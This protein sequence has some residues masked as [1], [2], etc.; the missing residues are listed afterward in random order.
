MKYYFSEKFFSD[1]DF[2]LHVE[3]A[4]QR[5]FMV[6]HGHDFIELVLVSSGKSLH[7]I[8]APAGAKASYGLIRGEVF[9]VMPGEIHS[10]CD[11]KNFEI[12]N[13]AFLPQLIAGEMSEL[14]EL[15]GIRSLLSHR[16]G[17]P[18]RHLY[19]DARC[20][21]AA[22]EHLH[23]MIYAASRRPP[24]WKLQTKTAFLNF[25]FTIGSL[26]A[27][28]R[29]PDKTTVRSHFLDS[30]DYLEKNIQRKIT[31]SHLAQIACMSVSSYTAFFRQMIGLSPMEYLI[32]LRL[33]QVR[34]LLIYS[35]M[36]LSEIAES[37]GFCDTNYMI[38][39]FRLREK[40]TPGQL[41]RSQKSGN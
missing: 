10:Y 33:N 2:S 36:E 37:C 9:T 6:D 27:Q 23:K 7:R 11:S 39:M 17:E 34:H 38:K 32:N 41:R 12:Y 26:K 18:H 8:A 21:E 19:L 28:I 14:N 22:S 20:R 13:V 16:P 3:K 30:L 5:E 35:N 24:A 29:E 40:T 4:R 1:P 25:L 15:P 31:L